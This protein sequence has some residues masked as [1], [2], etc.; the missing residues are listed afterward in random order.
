VGLTAAAPTSELIADALEGK[1]GFASLEPFRAD[2][3]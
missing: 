1:P 2:R 3:F